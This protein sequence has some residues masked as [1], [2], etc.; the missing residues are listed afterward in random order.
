MEGLSANSGST[1]GGL[2]LTV[3]GQNFDD[4]D[5]PAR[6]LIDGEEC[7]VQEPISSTAIVCETPPPPAAT[8]PVHAGELSYYLR[9]TIT[10]LMGEF[11][12]FIQMNHHHY[13]VLVSCHHANK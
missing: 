7:R 13:Y 1:E 6:V 4:T 12:P 2:F 10:L 11:P 5:S 9:R 3:T 8:P